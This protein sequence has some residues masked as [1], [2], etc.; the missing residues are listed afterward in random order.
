MVLILNS[1]EYS[2][3]TSNGPFSRK[4]QT[5]IL[6]HVNNGH[7]TYGAKKLII[8]KW[9]LQKNSTKSF[10]KHSHSQIENSTPVHNTFVTNNFRG[11]F[12][13]L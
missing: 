10:A 6:F 3:V 12:T 8:I 9:L 2:A 11:Y 1:L 7:W 5:T 4:F 13:V